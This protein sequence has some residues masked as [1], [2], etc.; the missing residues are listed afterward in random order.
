MFDMLVN[1][2]S[3]K[4]KLPFCLGD[5]LFAVVIDKFIK[6]EAK[7]FPRMTVKKVIVDNIR[8]NLDIDMETTYDVN[9]HWQYNRDIFK[10]KE[11]AQMVADSMNRNTELRIKSKG[12]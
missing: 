12:I 4:I 7:S 8:V 10:T 11:Q 6:Y 3:K 9:I 5:E 1:K 2:K